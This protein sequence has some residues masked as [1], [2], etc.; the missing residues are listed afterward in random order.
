MMGLWSDGWFYIASAGLLISGVLFFFLLGQYR[1]ASEAADAHE[2][3]APETTASVSAAEAI[4]PVYL[5]EQSSAPVQVASAEPKADT[6]SDYP[7]PDRRK[8]NTTGGVSPAV[9]YMQNIKSE[10]GE[11]HSDVRDLAK[12]LDAELAAVSTRD[13]ALIERLTELTRAVEAMKAAAPAAV[14]VAEPVAAPAPEPKKARKEK[15][16]GPPIELS[17]VVEPAP[18]PKIEAKPE[19]KTE[20][21]IELVEPAPAPKAETISPD[22]TIRMELGALIKSEPK[23]PATEPIVERV[24]EPVVEPAPAAQEPAPEEK[25]RRGPVW[26]V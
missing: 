6:K 19:P 5:S 25:P 10:L 17:A 23:T 11:L 12:R 14:A 8:E 1:L 4:R 3:D 21:K 20:P 9:V 22:E 2:G 24:A 13:E 26:P 16:P 7:G 18:E 15:L